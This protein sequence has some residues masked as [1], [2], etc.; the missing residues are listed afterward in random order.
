[1][2]V[3]TMPSA[4]CDL[5]VEDDDFAPLDIQVFEMTAREVAAEYVK[6]PEFRELNQIWKEH[7]SRSRSH[8]WRIAIGHR[9]I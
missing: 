5:A 4:Y 7:Q 6:R 3:K 2:E 9:G 8:S 1:M